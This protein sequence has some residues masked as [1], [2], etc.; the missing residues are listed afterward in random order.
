MLIAAV[1]YIDYTQTNKGLNYIVISFVCGLH[2]SCLGLELYGFT[3][4][5]IQGKARESQSHMPY[6]QCNTTMNTRF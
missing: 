6:I 4:N 2:T 5:Y 1:L 3:D